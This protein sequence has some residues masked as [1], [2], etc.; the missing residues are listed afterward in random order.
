MPV[1]NI[2]ENSYG[3]KIL[4]VL[5]GI[6]LVYG[7][8]FLGTLIRNNLEKFYFIG[9]A[10]RSERIIL[11]EAQGKV[12]VSPDVAITTMGMTSEAVTVAEAQKKNTDVMNKLIEKLKVLGIEAKDIQT[13]SYNVY[14]QYNYT[15]KDGQVLKGYQV[16]QSVTIKIRNLDNATKV[17]SLA[18]EVGANNVSGIS[19]IIDDR[20]KYK[21][22]AREIAIEKVQTKI[23]NLSRVL[24][25][26]VVGVVS[27]NEYEGSGYQPEYAAN[28]VVKS[29]MG[30]MGGAAPAIEPG[31]TDV[32]LNVNVTFEIR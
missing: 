26:R 15:D 7:I 17:L 18:G 12:R 14:P 25:V 19:F 11:V 9:K 5:V 13:A 31:N 30:G 22:Q 10:D 20:E 27:Y 3:R 6:L 24:G 2:S 1:K 32:T 29:E 16:S 28:M 21:E 8:V 4:L 23:I